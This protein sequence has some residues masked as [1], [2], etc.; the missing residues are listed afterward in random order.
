MSAISRRKF[1]Y[2]SATL[3]VAMQFPALAISATGEIYPETLR[4]LQLAYRAEMVAHNHYVGFTARAVKEGFPNIAYLFKA[5]ATSE[6]IHADNY[7][8]TLLRLR[9]TAD[10]VANG[11]VV[12][13]TQSN[14]RTAAKNEL[15]K[16]EQTYPE[17]LKAL[18]TEDYDDAIVSSMWAWKSHRQHEKQIRRIDRYSGIFFDKVAGKIEKSVFDFHVC[19]ICGSTIDVPP[20][21][22]CEICNMARSHYRRISPPAAPGA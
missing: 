18:Q 12:E 10:Q 17:F 19:E 13:D 11:I 9:E 1:I 6:V 3:A 2:L 7:A 15:E 14:L 21:A 8:T 16:I 4:I 22:P 20:V 5:F